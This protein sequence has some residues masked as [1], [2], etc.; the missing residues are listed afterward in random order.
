[1][2]KLLLLATIT[3]FVSCTTEPIKQQKTQA[4]PQ[5]IHCGN[6]FTISTIYTTSNVFI[7]VRYEIVL[8]FPYFDGTN[9]YTKASIILNNPQNT[10]VL[11]QYN[12]NDNICGNVNVGYFYN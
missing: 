4:Q 1:M 7:G 6:V 3:L 2:K 12:I 5:A 9:T 8:D 10:Q 11:N